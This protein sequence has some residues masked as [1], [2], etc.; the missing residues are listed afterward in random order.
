MRTAREQ[1]T[2]GAHARSTHRDSRKL[3]DVA[4]KL[5]YKR[6][7]QPTR[8]VQSRWDALQNPILVH[9]VAWPSEE[10]TLRAT[11]PTTRHAAD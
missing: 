10:G 6:P 3:Q 8:D 1:R 7:V 9:A 4:L 11:R 5:Y 2:G